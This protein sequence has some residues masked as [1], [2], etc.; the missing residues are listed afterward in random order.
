MSTHA[1]ESAHAPTAPSPAPTPAP[2]APKNNTFFGSRWNAIKGGA[3]HLGS[4]SWNTVKEYTTVERS[5]GSPSIWGI[6]KG[7][8]KAVWDTLSWKSNR[9][10]LNVKGTSINPFNKEKPWT[11]NPMV[12]IRK[13]AAGTT[14]AVSKATGG[15]IGIVGQEKMGNAVEG[16][17]NAVSEAVGGA[18]L[19]DY[20]QYLSQ[21]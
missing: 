6:I 17:T 4:T 21:G 16:I 3:K 14:L 10:L 20:G 11:F 15:I 1:S 5:K 2:T 7:T 13:I 19:G 18:V 12:A 8:S 9:G